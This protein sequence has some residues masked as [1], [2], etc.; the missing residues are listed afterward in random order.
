[1]T[2]VTVNATEVLSEN[3]SISP[4]TIITTIGVFFGLALLVGIIFYIISKFNR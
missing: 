3:M 4:E 2:N 1:M